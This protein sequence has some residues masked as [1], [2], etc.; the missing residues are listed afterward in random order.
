MTFH[1][2]TLTG[3]SMRLPVL[4]IPA[5]V[6]SAHAQTPAQQVIQSTDSVFTL[7][8]PTKWE[9]SQGQRNIIMCCL[10]SSSQ[11]ALMWREEYKAIFE[12]KEELKK[13]N[14]HIIRKCLGPADWQE[15]SFWKELLDYVKSL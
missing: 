7:P 15:V 5:L 11:N 4:L 2:P 13:W 3:V 12:D 1:N 10:R 14:Q 9:M 6:I 8:K